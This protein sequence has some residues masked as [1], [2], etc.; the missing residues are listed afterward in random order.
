M[1]LV[2]PFRC[3]VRNRF[4][5][6][7][8]HSKPGTTVFPELGQSF[9]TGGHLPPAKAPTAVSGCCEYTILE[10]SVAI[11]LPRNGIVKCSRNPRLNSHSASVERMRTE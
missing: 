8:G 6:L 3:D 10:L 2:P 1:R 4:M 7:P 9:D 5:R 11:I